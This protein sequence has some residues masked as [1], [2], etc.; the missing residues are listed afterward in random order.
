METR[1]ITLSGGRKATIKKLNALDLIK[2]SSFAGN[3]PNAQ[4]INLCTAVCA[5]TAID[6]AAVNPL[7]SRAQFVALAGQL[8]G[9]DLILIGLV[10]Q[11][12]ATDGVTD[13]QKKELEAL[14]GGNS[15]D[16][17]QS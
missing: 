17:L 14:L 16:S 7:G 4:V 9:E 12:M 15:D 8:A 3:D 2:A 13:E 10:Q 11:K 1:E 5:V 6:D